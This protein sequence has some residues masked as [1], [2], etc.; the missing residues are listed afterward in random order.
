MAVI[1]LMPIYVVGILMFIGVGIGET[2][3]FALGQ[4]LV[5]EHSDNE[6]RARMTSLTMMTY[7][8]I[9]VAALAIGISV[10]QFGSQASIVGMAIG[11]LI[12]SAAFI[13]LTPSIRRL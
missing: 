3:R 11:L 5:V 8:F 7:G 6:Y 10:E 4:A 2:T 12:V 13:V 9:P 1:G